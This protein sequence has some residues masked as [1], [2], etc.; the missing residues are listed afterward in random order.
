M[1]IEVFTKLVKKVI[2]DIE[3]S[4]EAI[5]TVEDYY[6]PLTTEKDLSIIW[7]NSDIYSNTAWIKSKSAYY[8]ISY[9]E[10]MKMVFIDIYK[11]TKKAPIIF[12]IEE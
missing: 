7:I 12:D 8:E 3:N 1:N 4:D 11:K 9:S 6:L 2:I 10:D 5:T